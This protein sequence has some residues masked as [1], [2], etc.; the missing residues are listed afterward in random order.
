MPFHPEFFF[1][2][3]VD[4]LCYGRATP[5][6]RR[7]EWKKDGARVTW[8]Y[9]TDDGR[10][11]DEI[12]RGYRRR[13]LSRVAHRARPWYPTC[14]V[15]LFV[16]FFS[17]RPPQEK[18]TSKEADVICF[19]LLMSDRPRDSYFVFPMYRGL[20]VEHAKVRNTLKISKLFILI[21]TTFID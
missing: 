14:S 12:N 5:K 20:S 4:A 8:T 11:A 10:D 17:T 6:A 19:V 15:I 7:N 9:W 1:R 13:Y 21:S 16:F 3:V 2:S 18:T